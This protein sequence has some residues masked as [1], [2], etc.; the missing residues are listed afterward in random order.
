MALE[1]HRDGGR[2]A[3]VD[4]TLSCALR[5]L[6]CWANSPLLRCRVV[7]RLQN[8]LQQ[9]LMQMQNLEVAVVERYLVGSHVRLYRIEESEGTN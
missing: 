2:G 8:R 6:H 4:V 9:K 5:R 7:L 3:Q 1:N